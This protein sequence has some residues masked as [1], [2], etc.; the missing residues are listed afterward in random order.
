MTVIILLQYVSPILA[1]ANTLD[2]KNDLVSLKSAKISK[3]DDQTVTVDLKVTANNVT[4]QTAKTKIEFSNKAIVFKEA[5]NQLTTSK[6]QYKLNGQVLEATIAPNTSKEENNLS[7]KL[8]KASLK[9]IDNV[10]VSSGDSKTTL[11]LSGVT[12]L[13]EKSVTTESSSKTNESTSPASS[14]TS[15]S[16]K[17]EAAKE[18][19]TKKA[20]IKEKKTTAAKLTDAEPQANRLND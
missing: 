13:P 17:E 10:Q 5:L 9:G 4:E 19:D 2:E 16:S 11:D 8:D 18:D 6:N 3:Q 14:T 20:A 12:Q 1:V 7:I 15:S